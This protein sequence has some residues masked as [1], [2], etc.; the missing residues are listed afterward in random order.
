MS[1]VVVV[2]VYFGEFL[3]CVVLLLVHE[4]ECLSVA[5][6]RECCVQVSICVCWFCARFQ[7]ATDR[8]HILDHGFLVLCPLK[9]C[10]HFHSIQVRPWSELSRFKGEWCWLSDALHVYKRHTGSLHNQPLTLQ[11]DPSL[12]VFEACCVSACTFATRFATCSSMDLCETS[13]LSRVEW[14]RMVRSLCLLPAS[15]C[16]APAAIRKCCEATWL[17]VN[18]EKCSSVYKSNSQFNTPPRQGRLHAD[19][20]QCYWHSSNAT[21]VMIFS[22]MFAVS[23]V[24]TSSSWWK[25]HQLT[26]PRT[27]SHPWFQRLKLKTSKL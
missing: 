1:K 18:S 15:S 25:L 7:E 2:Q 17:H 24:D 8:C 16:S 20:G 4:V 23:K 5:Q 10:L 22:I 19:C 13:G 14:T 26:L 11:S 27:R 6:L 9:R 21:F 12:Q 3:R